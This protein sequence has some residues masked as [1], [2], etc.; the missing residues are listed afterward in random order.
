VAQTAKG[1][2]F[3]KI[4]AYDRVVDG[5]TVHVKAHDRSNPKT[6]SGKK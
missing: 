5:K 3:N 1:Q 4:P 6:S 2:K